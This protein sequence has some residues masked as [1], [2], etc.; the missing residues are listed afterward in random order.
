MEQKYAVA[1]FTASCTVT[2]LRSQAF[3]DAL[4]VVRI[5]GSAVEIA[6]AEHHTHDPCPSLIRSSAAIQ[7][8]INFVHIGLVIYHRAVHFYPGM[9]SEWKKLCAE[10]HLR[11]YS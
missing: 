10:H 4:H 1:Q 2:P 3:R 6:S 11:C 8:L 9:C 5:D 7:N